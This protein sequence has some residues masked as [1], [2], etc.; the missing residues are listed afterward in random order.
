M[1]FSADFSRRYEKLPVSIFKEQ[2]DASKLILDFIIETNNQKI[3][4]GK[5]C[6]L[7]L[8]ASSACIQLYE[9]M[10]SAYENGTLNFNN[11]EIFIM[12]EYYPLDR[13]E[14]QSHYRFFKE[15]IFD[16]AKG[17]GFFFL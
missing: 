6:V 4:E 9:D 14:L 15:Y 12:D 1:N 10:V 16:F 7:A 3:A 5:K 17:F 2:S 11:I 8:S 13:N